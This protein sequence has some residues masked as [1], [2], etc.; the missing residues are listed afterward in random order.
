MSINYTI[1]RDEVTIKTYIRQ[2]LGISARAMTKLKQGGIF[3]NGEIA[4][5]TKTMRKGDVLT[6]VPDTT[7]KKE[8]EKED[9]PIDILFED[10]NFLVIDKKPYMAVYPAGEH[11][12]GSLL[13]AVAFM[14]KD[15]TFRPIYRLDRNT[16]GVIVIAKNKI[17]ASTKV[18]KKEY[19]AV[20]EGVAPESGEINS[21]ICL[22]EGSRIKRDVGAGQEAKTNF[23][24]LC[25]NDSHSLLKVRIHT[26][27]THQIRV[28]LSS[29]NLPIAG[30]DLYGGSTEYIKRQALHCHKICL[31]NKA[32]NFEKQIIS[33]IKD[34]I[35]GSFHQL[36]EKEI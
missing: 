4:F 31:E 8:Y 32:L 2:H 25:H 28:H 24:R 27:R 12:S 19:L 26:G 33:E 9:I 36:F 18:T 5:V 20:C 29:I 16:S 17:S 21:P 14:R 3:L 1:E 15:I 22:A 7:V 23:W 35:R 10:D 30:D 6:L 11:I 13:N 34:D